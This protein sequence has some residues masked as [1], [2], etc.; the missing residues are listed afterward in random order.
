MVAHPKNYQKMTQFMDNSQTD[1]FH[2]YT[3]ELFDKDTTKNDKVDIE[4]YVQNHGFL[5]EAFHQSWSQI[6]WTPV[7]RILISGSHSKILLP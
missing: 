2:P 7:T 1:N 3:E 4:K 6:D 5:I